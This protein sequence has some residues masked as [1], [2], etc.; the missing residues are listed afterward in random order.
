MQLGGK[1][2]PYWGKIPF[3]L[4]IVPTD[5]YNNHLLYGFRVWMA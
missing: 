2:P 5:L 4:C 3:W 1:N